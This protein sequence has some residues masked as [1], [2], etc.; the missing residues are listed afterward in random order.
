MDRSRASDFHS[1][2]NRRRFPSGDRSRPYNEPTR[3]SGHHAGPPDPPHRAPR[4]RSQPRDYPTWPAPA[5]PYQHM[6]QPTSYQ[7][8]RASCTMLYGLNQPSRGHHQD[9]QFMQNPS[10]VPL[11]GHSL[12]PRPRHRSRDHG[13]PTDRRDATHPHTQDPSDSDSSGA[14]D[15]P[16][17]SHSPRSPPCKAP[18]RADDD[19]PGYTTPHLVTRNLTETTPRRSRLHSTRMNQDPRPLET[20]LTPGHRL[21]GTS[22]TT[23]RNP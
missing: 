21:R 4:D 1:K 23:G 6:P 2:S 12:T 13:P 22:T 15:S 5:D 17:W 14:E 3:L 9:A 10:A 18:R 7:E 11:G 8:P 16:Q 19:F 20:R